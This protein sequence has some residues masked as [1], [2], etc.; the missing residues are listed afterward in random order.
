MGEALLDRLLAAWANPPAEGDEA[1]RAFREV[2]AD[3]VRLNGAE[4]PVT[5]LVQRGRALHAAFAEL[6]FEVLDRVETADRIAVVLRHRARHV[7]PLRTPLGDVAPT[8]RVV[9]VL[10]IDVVEVAGDRVAGLWVVGD[11]LGRLLQLGA[12]ALAG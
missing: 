10:S 6:R 8:G 5:T 7:A 3:P 11:D 1:V 12:L 4:V 2:Y 9:E